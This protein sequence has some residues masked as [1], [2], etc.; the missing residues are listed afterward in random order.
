[1]PAA[2][3]RK[4]PPGCLVHIVYENEAGEVSPR[5]VRV[6]RW[7]HGRNGY[8]Y[9]KGYCFMRGEDRTFRADRILEWSIEEEPAS[10][11]TPPEVERDTWKPTW[12]AR[13]SLP[14]PSIAVSLPA[15]RPVVAATPSAARPGRKG[16]RGFLY[17]FRVLFNGSECISGDTRSLCP[18]AVLIRFRMARFQ[19]A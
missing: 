6:E 5:R 13:E 4:A 18:M 2:I 10:G 7:V 12:P 9:L 11:W 16:G 3:S 17:H 8:S 19:R 1:L 14:Q 15:R